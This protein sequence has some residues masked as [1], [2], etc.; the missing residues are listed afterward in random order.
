M[1]HKAG[2][3]LFKSLFWALCGR[4]FTMCEKG[5]IYNVLNLEHNI[6]DFLYVCGFHYSQCTSQSD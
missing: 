6:P 5:L 2:M 1:F 3:G 4:H